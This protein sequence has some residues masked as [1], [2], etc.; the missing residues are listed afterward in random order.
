MADAI[1]E[2]SQ[3]ARTRRAEMSA[4]QERFAKE[5]EE[6]ED[7]S[8]VQ[9]KMRERKGAGPADRRGF[10]KSQRPQRRFE[11]RADENTHQKAEQKAKE[12]GEDNPEEKK[13]A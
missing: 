3:I 6:G 9:R 2:G 5:Q 8:K 7:E 4:D 12:A 10:G 13:N 1:A 11:E